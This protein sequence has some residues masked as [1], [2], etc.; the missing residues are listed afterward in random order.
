[1][2]NTQFKNASSSNLL[3]YV[4]YGLLFLRAVFLISL[5]FNMAKVL[6]TNLLIVELKLVR[7]VVS[8]GVILHCKTLNDD[9]VLRHTPHF[10]GARTVP[11]C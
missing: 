11:N 6:S 1:M 8:W 5:L 10:H 3:T 7:L 4:I 2:N 9:V